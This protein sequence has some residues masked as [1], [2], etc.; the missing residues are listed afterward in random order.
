MIGSH[1]RTLSREA[2]KDSGSHIELEAS[3]ERYPEGAFVELAEARLESLRNSPTD[4]AVPNG[5]VSEGELTFWNSIKDSEIRTCFA[6]YLNKYPDGIYAELAQINLDMEKPS[7]CRAPY[8]SITVFL[9]AV[10]QKTLCALLATSRPALVDRMSG[11]GH[12]RTLVGGSR[13]SALPPKSGHTHRRRRCPLS[14]TNGHSTSRALESSFPAA[15][16]RPLK[17][18]LWVISRH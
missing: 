17:R 11:L 3:V 1:S 12:S 18:P 4:L 15:K 9:F 6:A 10:F 14:A 16:A 2:A 5:K 7:M 8:P 13:I